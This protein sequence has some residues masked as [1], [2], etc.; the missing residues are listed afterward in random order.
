MGTSVIAHGNSA[1]VFE[2]AKHDFYFVSLLIKL[3][4]IRDGLFPASPGRN[5]RSNPFAEQG[6]AEPVGI[7]AS[8]RQQ[9][10]S[11]GQRAE[12]RRGTFIVAHLSFGQ[13]EYYR[14]AGCIA[15]SMEF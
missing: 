13:V 5:A 3:F 8:I 9:F 15:N 14:L 6:I 12:Q 10:L 7:I 2:P 1:P 4:V 11:Q